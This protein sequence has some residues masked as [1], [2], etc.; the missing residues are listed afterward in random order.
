MAGQSESRTRPPMHRIDDRDARTPE[1]PT[2][3]T[4]ADH[5]Q[6]AR[7]SAAGSVSTAARDAG[8]SPCD[9]L[10]G[11]WRLGVEELT[12]QRTGLG[13]WHSSAG[14][15]EVPVRW[16]CMQDGTAEVRLPQET[17]HLVVEA[18]GGALVATDSSG[19]RKSGRRGAP[20]Q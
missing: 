17:W 9:S 7:R 4:L 12:L 20:G 11:A 19:A 14:Q 6:A 2:S 16:L 5:A 13:S 10:L 18:D 15:P 1:P 3:R 8:N